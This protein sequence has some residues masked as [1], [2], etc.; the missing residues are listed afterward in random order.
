MDITLSGK[1][2][3]VDLLIERTGISLTLNTDKL[4]VDSVES[5]EHIPPIPKHNIDRADF[6]LISSGITSQ[7]L[8]RR[9]LPFPD[10]IGIIPVIY[11]FNELDWVPV[12]IEGDSICCNAIQKEALYN[13]KVDAGY[14]HDPMIGKYGNEIYCL[15]DEL[16]LLTTE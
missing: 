13:Y 5:F 2:V 12:G 14:T 16:I 3:A 8:P 1:S 6:S 15:T 7:L 10:A 9:L 11:R 4:D